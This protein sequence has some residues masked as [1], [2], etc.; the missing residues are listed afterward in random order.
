M[1]HRYWVHVEF[2]GFAVVEVFATSVQEAVQ[3]V[4]PRLVSPEKVEVDRE[5]FY[6]TWVE[7]ENG[8]TVWE[9]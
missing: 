6:P 7:D 5:E 1:L 2:T 9:E 4:T 3:T 8:K